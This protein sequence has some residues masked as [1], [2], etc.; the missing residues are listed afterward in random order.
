MGADVYVHVNSQFQ[1]VI[2]LILPWATIN[3]I[4][5]FAQSP[6]LHRSESSDEAYLLQLVCQ[7][8]CVLSTQ[9]R[10]CIACKIR[11]LSTYSP[12]LSLTSFRTLYFA[13]QPLEPQCYR[14]S[15]SLSP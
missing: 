2:D 4:S 6:I 5:D 10:S 15:K 14:L 1:T 3:K 9:N 11:K 13:Q 12:L 7:I 8:I